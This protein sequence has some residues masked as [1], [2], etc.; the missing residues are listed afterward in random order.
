MEKKSILQYTVIGLL[1]MLLLFV[2]MHSKGL[3]A[4]AELTEYM[5]PLQNTDDE[6]TPDVDERITVTQI[7]SNFLSSLDIKD[8]FVN[9]TGKVLKLFGNQTYFRSKGVVLTSDGYAIGTYAKTSTDYEFNELTKLKSFLDEEG[10]E[11]LYVNAPLKYLDDE[12]CLREIGMKSYGNENGD[13]FMTRISEAGVSNIDLRTEM[14]NDGINSWDMFYRTDHHWTIPA[15]FWATKKIVHQLNQQGFSIDESLYDEDKYTTETYPQ[16]W[17]GEQGR[18]VAQSYIGLDD[19]TCM[20]P[21]FDTSFTFTMANGTQQAG[22]FSVM[23]NRENYG[24]TD[25]YYNRAGLHYSYIGQ[26]LGSYNHMKIVNNNVSDGKI[27]YLG[28]SYSYTVLPFLIEG[29]SEID[30]IIMRDNTAGYDLYQQVRDGDYDAVVICYANFM[31]GAH[32]NSESANYRMFSFDNV[33]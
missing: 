10:V 19:Y 20:Y 12:E 30:G 17:L 6:T 24:A 27:L 18:L 5:N 28:D 26:T 23:M 9:V 29:V 15:G 22:D 16:C 4:F 13:V 2:G 7:E 8:N 1:V 32:D 11:L 31:I 21:N 33:E 25:D 14:T 3:S